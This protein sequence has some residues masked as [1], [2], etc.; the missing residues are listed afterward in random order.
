MARH[1]LSRQ[2]ARLMLHEGTVRGQKITPK[3]RRFFGARSSGAPI[4]MA[5]RKG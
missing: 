1:G 3:Q 2:K 4:R 5:R